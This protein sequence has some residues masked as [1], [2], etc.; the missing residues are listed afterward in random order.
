LGKSENEGVMSKPDN[1]L[2]HGYDLHRESSFSNTQFLFNSAKYLRLQHAKNW[3]IY[4]TLDQHTRIVKARIAFY[5]DKDKA[6]SPLRAPFG[7]IEV[8]QKIVVDE[9]FGFFSLVETDLKGHGV[10]RMLLTSYPEAY[11]KNVSHAETAL[12]RLHYSIEQ[13]VSSV[14]PVDRKLFEKKI[15]ISEL[16][17][18]RKAEKMFSFEK[19]DL[20]KL[21]EIYS[22]IEEC[23]KERN[24]HLSMSYS[25]LKKTITEFPDNYFLYHVYDAAG[26]AAAAIVIRINQEIMYTFYYAHS[27]K[28]DK[29]SPVVFLI[30]SLYKEAQ[31]HEL[32][33]IDLGTSMLNGKINRSLLHFKKSIGGESTRKLIFEKLLE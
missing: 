16:Q 28:F 18:L 3:R 2:F 22:F 13:E 31:Q 23:R 30:S 24:Q 7:F 1:F 19:L 20:S 9:L 11:D 33:M 6:V 17:K 12:K 15:K 27:K 21:K 29:V 26:T 8:Y 14:I 4:E 5:L 10:K 25:D 32:K